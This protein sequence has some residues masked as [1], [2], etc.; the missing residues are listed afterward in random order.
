L[1]HDESALP[2]GVP[3]DPASL[4]TVADLLGEEAP[5][6][7]PFWENFTQ[8]PLQFE[9][10]WPPSG[11]R[12]AVWRS[13]LRYEP[14]APASDPWLAAARLVLLA[15]L[16]SWPSGHRPHAWRNH[17]GYVAPTL[18]LQVSLLGLAADEEW[19][20][21][22]GTSPVAADGL[23]AFTSRIWTAAGRLVAEGG[24]QTLFRRAAPP[25]A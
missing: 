10:E 11:P 3:G 22:E 9:A 16:P 8:K 17:D 4:P 13:W 21:L 5:A 1:E 25:G 24:G 20:L 18:D 23:M 12:D 2:D 7:F 14:W 19:L 15:D 6:P